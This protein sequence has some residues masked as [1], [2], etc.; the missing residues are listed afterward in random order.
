MEPIVPPA[1]PPP[2]GRRLPLAP[3][4]EVPASA[5]ARRWPWVVSGVV[6]LLVLTVVGS[7]FV[8]TPYYRL[9]PGSVRT[10]ESLIEVRG[11]PSYADDAGE[12]GYTTISLG[13][14]T[15]FELVTGW[16][17]PD[18]EI[19][20]RDEAF[21]GTDPDE[22]RERNLEAMAVSKDV[23]AV[24][25]LEAL[26]YEVPYDGDGAQVVEVVADGPAAAAG[27]E[28][29]DTIVAIDG[30]PVRVAED[31]GAAV[32]G[33]VPGDV[34]T[35]TVEPYPEDG[36]TVAHASGDGADEVPA[37][38]DT[39][40]GDADAAE[41]TAVRTVEVALGE[42]PDDPA[43][44]F[45]G[46][47]TMTRG[48]TF[49]LP[50]DVTIDTGQVGGP[51][52]GLAF[53]LGIVDVLTPGDLTGG[54]RVATTGTINLAGDVGPIGGI[55]QKTAAVRAAGVELFLVPPDEFEAAS[56]AAGSDLE[57]VAVAT[58]DDALEALAARGGDTAPVEQQ[59]A[60]GS[61][62]GS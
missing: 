27:L 10:T 31:V 41:P 8:P 36:A 21:P 15:A 62:G 50:V 52:A 34:V 56:A 4:G 55:E 2:E 3:D 33:L 47:A 43:A 35:V 29:G 24:V 38:T 22:S 49:D 28:V 14:A 16:F 13:P 6:V 57:V 40:D 42:R 58:L 39:T 11:A 20:S 48:L 60:G 59:A 9:A 51:S 45:L 54:R 37:G 17:D 5:R 7:L 12:I 1:D 61:A 23:A 30:A 46:V 44:A 18:V 25:A 32:D 19:L 26:G 53:S